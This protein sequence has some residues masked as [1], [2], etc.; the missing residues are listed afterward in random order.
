VVEAATLIEVEDPDTLATQRSR[1]TA[2]N[3]AV[4]ARDPDLKAF[5]GTACG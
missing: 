2:G 4:K 3:F 1:Q 5:A